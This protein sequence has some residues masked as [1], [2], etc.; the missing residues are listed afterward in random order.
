M[1]TTETIIHTPGLIDPNREPWTGTINE[2]FQQAGDRAWDKLATILADNAV[3]DEDSDLA[4]SLEALA[5][6]GLDDQELASRLTDDPN[7][8]IEDPEEVADAIADALKG[9]QFR[10][11]YSQRA[12]AHVIHG[13]G[14]DLYWTL[15][16]ECGTFGAEWAL[17]TTDED[18]EDVLD[19]NGLAIYTPGPG[20]AEKTATEL[21][22]IAEATQQRLMRE[23]GNRLVAKALSTIRRSLDGADWLPNYGGPKG[24]GYKGIEFRLGLTG[25]SEPRIVQTW[26]L[27]DADEDEDGYG[28]PDDIAETLASLNAEDELDE[29]NLE[30]QFEQIADEAI[31]FLA[32][33]D[34]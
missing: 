30:R 28:L 3:D 11:G 2:H 29:E 12:D 14:F 19:V 27:A 5:D 34:D 21:L 33:L 17:W 18:G 15:D 13:T 10:T 26:E 32:G 1:L 6:A 24:I 20:A 25:D 16:G 7:V 9:S 4:E 8:I 22:Q 23:Q 31:E